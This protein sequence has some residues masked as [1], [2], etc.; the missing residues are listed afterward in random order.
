MTLGVT[1]HLKPDMPR[2]SMTGPPILDS[3]EGIYDDGEWIS[4]DWINGQLYKQELQEEYPKADPEIAELFE[5]LLQL[6]ATYHQRTGRYLQIWGELGE[7][8][9]E[10]KV[11]IK[12]HRTKAPGYSFEGEG[13]GVTPNPSFHPT[14]YGLRPPHAGDL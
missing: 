13:K 4:W 8:Y 11:G 7:L 3:S 14:C 6:A 1:G 2:C 9:A 12:R 5:S 10:V